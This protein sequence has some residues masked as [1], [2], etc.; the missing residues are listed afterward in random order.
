MRENEE[1]WI[2]GTLKSHHDAMAYIGNRSFPRDYAK[3][4]T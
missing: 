4:Y 2:L 1:V 3:N